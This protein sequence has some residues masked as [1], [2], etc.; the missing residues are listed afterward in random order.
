MCQFIENSLRADRDQ[1]KAILTE[2]GKESNQALESLKENKITL[3]RYTQNDRTL[4]EA[5]RTGSISYME[6]VRLRQNHRTDGL[7]L[8]KKYKATIDK[9]KKKVDMLNST[10]ALHDLGNLYF[11]LGEKYLKEASLYW[12]EALDEVFQKLHSLKHFRSLLK[13]Q[14][15]AV[16]TF[17]V[18]QLFHAVILLSKLAKCVYHNDVHMQRECVL[19]ACAIARCFFKIDLSLPQNAKQAG[20]VILYNITEQEALQV[21]RN[22]DPCCLL[23]AC[24]DLGH[25]SID[26]EVNYRALPLVSLTRMLSNYFVFD[27]YNS[28]KSQLLNMVLASSSGLISTSI[29]QMFRVVKGKCLPLKLHANSEEVKIIAGETYP[30]DDLQY[31]DDIT[32][33]D[34]RNKQIT[35][36][37]RDTSIANSEMKKLGLSNLNLFRF[38]RANLLYKICE[39][40]NTEKLEYVLQKIEILKEAEEDLVELI[41]FL[42]F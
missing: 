9:L 5:F 36:S 15:G 42:D 2:I 29:I 24:V 27:H 26:Y 7:N 33:Y 38:A 8:A 3:A 31:L 22:L 28:V 35:Q 41:K 23:E 6:S 10:I 11:S 37:V 18:T 20:N 19:M 13:D 32:P 14:K 34:D 25:L 30:F 39:K 1:T 4:N 17:G 21:R 40:E 16:Q 12:N